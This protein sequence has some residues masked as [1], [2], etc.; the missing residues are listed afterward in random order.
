MSAPGM[1]I[2]TGLRVAPDLESA[3]ADRG[4]GEGAADIVGD[5]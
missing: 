4:A 1:P 3:T 2:A 5:R